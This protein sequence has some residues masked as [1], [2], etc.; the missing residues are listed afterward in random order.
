MKISS[1]DAIRIQYLTVTV[2]HSS[3]VT[4]PGNSQAEAD[5]RPASRV[6]VGHLHQETRAW[7]PSILDTQCCSVRFLDLAIVEFRESLFLSPIVLLLQKLKI[8]KEAFYKLLLNAQNCSTMAYYTV[9]N[10]T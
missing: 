5:V 7:V 9:T 2:S 1:I 8:C 4:I 3:E 6:R 10:Y